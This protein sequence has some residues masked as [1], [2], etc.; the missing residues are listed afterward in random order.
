MTE[1]RDRGVAYANLDCPKAAL[2]DI[3]A[4]LAECPQ[5]SDAVLLRQQVAHLREASRRLN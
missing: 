5:A 4:Y 3:E 2:N 1:R